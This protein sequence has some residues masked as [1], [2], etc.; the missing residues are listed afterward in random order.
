M[1]NNIFSYINER[2]IL[3]LILFC[4]SSVLAYKM[5]KNYMIQDGC[6][7]LN[8]YED[9]LIVVGIGRHF[10]EALVDALRTISETI[11]VY[12]S[13]IED[14]DI[15]VTKN[16]SALSFGHFTITSSISISKEY[17][18]DE[19]INDRWVGVTKFLY[20]IDVN[21]AL[22]IKIYEEKELDGEYQGYFEMYNKGV[23]FSDVVK[24][25]K[26]MDIEINRTSP[27]YEIENGS[28][29]VELIVPL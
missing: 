12:F 23:E 4:V 1:K 6:S 29:Y 9:T 11:L 20:A 8:Q 7:N 19:I 10:P 2:L 26:G 25:L 28:I 5:P 24:E 21:N 15:W 13:E 18:N 3:F 22:L 16:K 17:F 14:N 27:L